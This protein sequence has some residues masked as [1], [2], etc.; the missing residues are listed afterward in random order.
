[1]MTMS[2][3]D[4]TNFNNDARWLALERK[5]SGS[6]GA[7]VY[8]VRTTGVYCRVG[9]HSR[10]PDRA[11]VRFFDDAEGA[12]RAGY[13]PCKRCG[14]SAPP[15]APNE[16]IAAACRRIEAE[17]RAPSLASLAA[18]A[19]LSTSRFGEAFRRATGL[20]PAAYARAT[21]GQ[22]LRDGLLEGSVGRGYDAAPGELGMTPARYAE[23]GVGEPI[24][25]GSASSRLGW[26]LAAATDRGFCWIELGD[27]PGSLEARLRARFAKATLIGDDPEF[28]ARVRQV[29][30]QV[31]APG[32]P[33]GLPLD[34]R[35]TAFQRLVWDA[36]RAIPAG[37]TA[38]YAE[39]ARGI[40][41]PSASR[42]VAGACASNELAVAIPCHRVVRGDGGLGG[43]RWG[44]GR[45]Q[46]LLDAEAE[47][48]EGVEG[49]PVPPID[50]AD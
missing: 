49:L 35:G 48:G 37:R 18:S 42:A 25:F 3:A 14:G 16:A 10:R 30:A 44:V 26:V 11:N 43:Y 15:P 22:K 7:F 45:K 12:E 27:D 34:I 46:A 29:V 21:R 13:R 31:E 33:F 6:A 50:P 17:G 38:T 5:D 28:A 40:G 41:R 9:C 39:V 23:G 8:A 2:G 24:R 1:M 36:L 20:T 32:R 47:G 19:G 4:A